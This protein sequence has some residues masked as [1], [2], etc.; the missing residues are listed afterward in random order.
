MLSQPHPDKSKAIHAALLTI[1]QKLTK[2]YV[3]LADG[4]KLR[5]HDAKLREFEAQRAALYAWLANEATPAQERL[6]RRAILLHAEEFRA[7]T[8]KLIRENGNQLTFET[9]SKSNPQRMNLT[10]YTPIIT[11]CDCAGAK[12]WHIPFVQQ[13]AA[14]YRAAKENYLP[15]NSAPI[16]LENLTTAALDSDEQ[17]EF[18]FVDV[19]RAYPDDDDDLH[20]A[21]RFMRHFMPEAAKVQAATVNY[22]ALFED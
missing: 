6:A 3:P 18:E 8:V 5:E 2:I 9:P 22:N 17:R 21:P 13:F 10:T 20:D 12:C 11:H 16:Q 4:D 14:D 15:S 7:V 1:W 19:V